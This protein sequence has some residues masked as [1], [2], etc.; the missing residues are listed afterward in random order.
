MKRLLLPL[1]LLIG[2][3]AFTQYVPLDVSGGLYRDGTNNP[4]PAYQTQIDQVNLSLDTTRVVYLGLGASSPLREVGK[5]QEMYPNFPDHNPDLKIIN[6]NKPGLTVEKMLEGWDR[7]MS[8]NVIPNLMSQGLTYNDVDIIWLKTASL[9]P[10]KLSA[11][12]YVAEKI[13]TWEQIITRI[14]S[15]FPNCKII[16]LSGRHWGTAEKHAEPNAYYT[17][18]IMKELIDRR[19]KDA[20]STEP[21]LVWAHPFETEGEDIPNSYGHIWATR[22]IE[23]DGV[24]P[25]TAGQE[26]VVN[27]M[28]TW[29]HNKSA[30]Y[31]WTDED[32]TKQD[33]IVP[34][35]PDTL[36]VSKGSHSN[37][38]LHWQNGFLFELSREDY[39]A[40]LA[41][42]DTVPIRVRIFDKDS[43]IEASITRMLA[44]ND[45]ML[46]HNKRLQVVLC[47]DLKTNAAEFIKYLDLFDLF[48]LQYLAIEGDNEY[49]SL[50]NFPH[51]ISFIKPLRDSLLKAR[52][53]LPF[54][55]PSM[56]RYMKKKTWDRDLQQYLLSEPAM[57]GVVLHLYPNK[58]YLPVTNHLPPVV[59]YTY[60]LYAKAVEAYFDTLIMQLPNAFY[61]ADKTFNY[62]DSVYNRDIWI[63][64][65]STP[66]TEIKNTLAFSSYIWEVL[67][68]YD[69]RAKYWFYHNGFSPPN[70]GPGVR[71]KTNRVDKTSGNINRL[72]YYV[73]QMFRN[74]PKGAIYFNSVSDNLPTVDQGYKSTYLTGKYNYSGS[75]YSYFMDMQSSSAGYEVD[76]IKTS[77]S[78]F[79]GYGFGY[80]SKSCDTTY[81]YQEKWIDT[82]IAIPA[83]RYEYLP[84][85]D[86]IKVSFTQKLY[87][88]GD[89]II[90]LSS[91]RD[92]I[93][94]VTDTIA[95]FYYKDTTIQKKTIIKVEVITCQKNAGLYDNGFTNFILEDG[96]LKRQNY[97]V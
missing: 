70:G 95:V 82:T 12:A 93:F 57:D 37:V 24:H 13:P 85:I 56:G 1:L 76:G 46:A 36:V 17:S 49:Y 25:N 33:T 59:S 71:T 35:P 63:T 50:G 87:E 32:Y 65:F 9:D 91:K 92:S 43:N 19:I 66:T 55:Y 23:N 61:Y 45:T 47:V 79:K 97:S 94:T 38:G 67:N 11:D 18:L 22:F 83:I 7:Y 30:K 40:F 42:G 21:L 64:E 26:L 84:R 69:T 28:N 72:D 51:Y 6:G 20:T 86:T 27:Y 53:N 73:I 10:I 52:P 62:M 78:V 88:C 41:L 89:D 5:L 2:S 3:L 80:Y 29:F 81:T 48:D 39:Q 77:N 68:R 74:M 58:D 34:P 96:I 75:G 90:T 60:P 15:Q 4:P 54:L 44:L 14:H 8:A 31:W 16:Y